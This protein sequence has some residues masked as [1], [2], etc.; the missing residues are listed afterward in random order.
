M[1]KAEA[2]KG[3]TI[4]QPWASLVA[5][6][7]KVIETRSRQHP[8]RSAIGETIAIHAAVK[9]LSR[10][11]KRDYYGIQPHAAYQTGL[12]HGPVG[13]RIVNALD[14]KG[15]RSANGSDLPLG[16]VLATALLVDVVPIVSGWDCNNAPHV[17]VPTGSW[18]TLHNALDGP[19]PTEVDIESQRPF[20][21]YSDGRF[22][23]LLDNIV[24]CAPF[25]C[26]GRQGVWTVPDDVADNLVAWCA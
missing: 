9:P 24:K 11:I 23:L 17:C 12:V 19:E 3:I 18:L 25:P 10:Q 26:R 15:Y 13:A 4:L 7:I 1:G 21:D 16:A 14:A 22:A 20:G 2:V 6:G 8:W 5:E